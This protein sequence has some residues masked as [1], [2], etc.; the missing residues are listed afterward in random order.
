MRGR[1]NAPPFTSRGYGRA[2]QDFQAVACRSHAQSLCATPFPTLSIITPTP[3]QLEAASIHH[4]A[5]RR[6]DR[7][8]TVLPEPAQRTRVRSQR[9]ALH[10]DDA[11]KGTDHYTCI[12]KSQLIHY[13]FLLH[14]QATRSPPLRTSEPRA[15]KN[16]LISPTTTSPSSPTS[17]KARD[18]RRFCAQGIGF[19]GLR[20]M[21]SRACRR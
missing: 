16:A 4:E 5:H 3:S 17:R 18:C 11:L 1:S 20:R 19:S 15:T 21:L 9:Y 12:G 13:P 2:C 7:L 6:A 14:P 10:P 8:V